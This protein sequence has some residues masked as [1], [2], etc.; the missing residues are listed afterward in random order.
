MIL[1]NYNGFRPVNGNVIRLDPEPALSEHEKKQ[2]VLGRRRVLGERY[3]V[4]K[5]ESYEINHEDSRA[6]ELILSYVNMSSYNHIL[7]FISQYGFPINALKLIN[8]NSSGIEPNSFVEVD[9]ILDSVQN[10]RSWINYEAKDSAQREFAKD[11]LNEFFMNGQLSTWL[12]FSD[13]N[14]YLEPRIYVR[15]LFTFSILHILSWKQANH[16]LKICDYCGVGFQPL[17]KAKK[18]T[19]YCSSNC[20]VYGYRN[21]R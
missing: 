7:A 1:I 9:D 15:N 5:F 10:L 4:E 3:H 14:E 16:P 21:Q 13:K 18:S 2:T 8:N 20:R 6:K 19:R 12:E 11:E 17:R